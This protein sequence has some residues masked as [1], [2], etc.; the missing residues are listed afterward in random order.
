MAL[1]DQLIQRVLTRLQSRLG[2]RVRDFQ[3][4]DHENGLILCGQVG[5]Y[6]CKQL[7]QEIVME[8][9]GLPIL[10]NEIEVQRAWFAPEACG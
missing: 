3:L 4:S 2:G 9:S 10:A 7:V 8:L 1:D 6:Y 5:T